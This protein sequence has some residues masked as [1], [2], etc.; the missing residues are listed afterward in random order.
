MAGLGETYTHIAAVL[1]YLEVSSRL[2]G[3]S[4]TCTQEACKWI[5]PSYL[6]KVEY[7]PIKDIN[8][9]SARRRKRTLDDQITAVGDLDKQPNGDSCASNKPRT[10]GTRSTESDLAL[11]FQNLSVGGTK[12]ATYFA[13]NSQLL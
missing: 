4:K 3:T 11:L 10:F 8:F 2:H 1:F 7:L 6:K 12:P 5:M 13:I 9:I